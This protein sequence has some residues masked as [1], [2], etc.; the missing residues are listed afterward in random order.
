MNT[1]KLPQENQSRTSLNNTTKQNEAPSG[2]GAQPQFQTGHSSGA[3]PSNTAPY[4]CIDPNLTKILRCSIDSLYLSYSGN[5]YEKW[6]K[7][8]QLLK[9]MAQS[10]DEME[11]SQAQVALGRHL[12]EL[13]GKG[14]G[15]FPYVLQ[16]GAL[17]ISLS[18]PEALSMPLSYAQLSSESL[19]FSDVEPLEADLRFVINT[20]GNVTDE[21]KISRV[22]LCIDFITNEPLEGINDN[23][24]VSRA[25]LI[26][27]YSNKRTFSGWVIGSGG[28]MSAR[29]YDKTLE[30]RKSKKDYLRDIWKSEGWDEKQTVWRLEFQF[31]REV[32]KQLNIVSIPD[33][34]ANLNNLWNYAT[35][36][37]LRL[38]IPNSKDETQTRWPN[39]PLWDVLS[40]APWEYDELI[41]LKRTHLTRPPS[42]ES[43]FVNGLG[44]ITSFMAL[45]GITD[46][47]EGFGEFLNQAHIYHDQQERFKG[48]RFGTYIETKVRQKGRKFNTL[49]NIGRDDAEIKQHARDYR[50]EKD[51]E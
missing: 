48:Y 24:W 40:D 45:E 17:R 23:A 37:W 36:D 9:I 50:K 10:E 49:N 34:L 4:N 47:G 43:L 51:G 22:D 11:K 1:M 31:R 6:N 27:R 19:T 7:K 32:L 5:L 29:L 44:G 46:L 41:K 42:R 20:I 30:I 3:P 2:S 25:H 21:P 13:M 15:R 12:F 18:K 26:N 8:F 28:A 38:T 16:D 39:H 35:H 33:L 14:D